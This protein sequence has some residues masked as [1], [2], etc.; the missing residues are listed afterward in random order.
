MSKTITGMSKQMIISIYEKLSK[1]ALIVNKVIKMM[2]I[3]LD[4]KTI[5]LIKRG[6]IKSNNATIKKT[7]NIG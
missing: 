4:G 6:V 5:F 7:N 2:P 3:I 1:K